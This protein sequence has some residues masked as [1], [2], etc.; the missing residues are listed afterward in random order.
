MNKENTAGVRMP[1]RRVVP[2]PRPRPPID[3]DI[4]ETEY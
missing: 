3:R 4:V 1:N 2:N